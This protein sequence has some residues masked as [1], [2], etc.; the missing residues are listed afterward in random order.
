MVRQAPHFFSAEDNVPK[1]LA[2]CASNNPAHVYCRVDGVELSY[3]DLVRR[4]DQASAVLYEE[5]VRPG[6]HVAVML[7]HHLD[8]IVTFFALMQLAAVQIPINTALKGIGLS[9]IFAHAHPEL[10]IADEAYAPVLSEALAER[11]GAMRVFWR[12]PDESQS[13]LAQSALYGG[14]QRA[15]APAVPQSDSTL[16]QILY[17]SGTT[18][19]AKGVIMPDRMLRAAALGS[20]WIGRI[21]PGSVLH[22]WDPIYHVFGTEVLV[23]ALMVPVTLVMVPRFSASRLWE[24]A[25]ANGVTHIHF[26]G[27][28]LQLLMKQP[29]SP[30][31]RDHG[32]KIAWGGGCPL[33]V[34]RPFEERFGV[35]IHEGY[36]MTETSSFSTIN[37]QGK[38]GSVGT[39]VP[40]FDVELVDD[41][42]RKL[43]AGEVGE[44][45]VRGKEPGVLVQAYY[46]NPE[47]T[48]GALREGWLYTGDL[49]RQDEEGHFH[50]IGRKKDSLRRRGE[51]VSAWEVERVF[52]QHPEV[53]ECALVGVRNEFADEDLKLFVKPRHPD[54]TPERLIA[55]AEPRMAAF[56]LP[57]FVAFVD[58]FQKTPTER[59]QK[60]FLARS[61]DDCWDR[62]K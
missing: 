25:R 47:A 60:Q 15:P 29:P 34:W 16:R 50:F 54:L 46:D 40:Y 32:V 39:A 23:L 7:S 51:N 31:D 62:G 33:E 21:E 30:L 44:I 55:W 36:G 24:E 4:V 17:T 11:G 26:V 53:E 10:L 61:I 13:A 43:P 42:G 48:A 1:L 19:A 14:P 45:R 6:M 18:G 12:K 3:A 9:H 59:I 37:P 57:R 28:V 27:G 5:G 56:Q 41:A 52:N 8:H 22:F 2:E 58:R 35:R 38:L 20:T 49:A